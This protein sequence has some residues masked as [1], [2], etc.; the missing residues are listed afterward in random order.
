MPIIAPP[1]W[2]EIKNKPD[3]LTGFGITDAFANGQTWQNLTASRAANTNYTNSTGRTITVT[4]VSA[5][6]AYPGLDAYIDG[7]KII[8]ITGGYH[9]GN[10][11]NCGATFIVP[12][13]STYKCSAFTS[14]WEL[15]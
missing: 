10:G 3:T 7:I 4:V 11:A 15:R 6:G 9:P 12:N 13:G 14:W 5:A 2:T 1:K 8:A